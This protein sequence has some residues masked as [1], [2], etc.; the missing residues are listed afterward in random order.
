MIIPNW[1]YIKFD[2][3]LALSLYLIIPILSF[4]G[5]VKVRRLGFLVSQGQQE[6]GALTSLLNMTQSDFLSRHPAYR[7]WSS[8]T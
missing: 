3:F 7:K 8:S 4:N 1:D 5:Q 2:I 6:D